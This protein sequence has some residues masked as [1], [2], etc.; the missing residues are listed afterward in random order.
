MKL[1][2]SISAIIL[3]LL[4]VFSSSSF[5]V[6]I[7]WCGGHVQDFA[8]FTKAEVCPMEKNFPPCH[9]QVKN[10]CCEDQTVAHEGSGF[11]ASVNT[12]SFEMPF[13]AEANVASVI[14]S[15][16]IPDSPSSVIRYPD[17]DPPTPTIDVTVDLQVFL[18]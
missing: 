10:H 3:A 14:I 13:V 7:H 16:I 18:I 15:Q 6:G 12:I 4:V 5:I 9:K 1:I 2:R 8:I 17:Y 11:K